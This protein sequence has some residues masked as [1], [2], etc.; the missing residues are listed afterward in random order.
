M[1]ASGIEIGKGNTICVFACGAHV[2][3]GYKMAVAE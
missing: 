3:T 2:I 1:A